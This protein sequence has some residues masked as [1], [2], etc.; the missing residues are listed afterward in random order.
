MTFQTAFL[1]FDGTLAYAT[2]LG[3][4]MKFGKACVAPLLASM[5]SS[6]ALANPPITVITPMTLVRQAFAANNCTLALPQARGLRSDA[7]PPTGDDWAWLN[8]I[9]VACDEK[10]GDNAATYKDALA[11]TMTDPS[12]I[13][14]WRMRLRYE[15]GEKR[16]HE[17]L[18]TIDAMAIAKPAAL[19]SIPIRAY[20][21]L[22]Q[23]FDTSDDAQSDVHLLRLLN[24]T[25]K[26]DEPF[27]DM[28]TLRLAYARRLYDAGDKVGAGAIINAIQSFGG[29]VEVSLDPDF[30]ALQDPK[31]DLHLA[32][33]RQYTEDGIAAAQ[34]LDIQGTMPRFLASSAMSASID[35]ALAISA[36]PS[37]FRPS[38]NLAMPRP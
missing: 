18:A 20:F 6:S 16:W 22:H 11:A 38:R 2:G 29:L 7:H 33:E 8:S 17:A 5:L 30:R 12:S 14:V 31:V 37:A 19:N 26:P 34:H 27:A 23:Q 35:L 1:Q 3:G 24:D 36:S 25:Y 10:A 32:A 4:F 28:E 13:Y 9:I 15:F 21:T